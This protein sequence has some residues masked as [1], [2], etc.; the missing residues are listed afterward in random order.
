MITCGTKQREVDHH[1]SQQ[2]GTMWRTRMPGQLT[3]SASAACTN[4]CRFSDSV[5][6]ARSAHVEP[7][8]R[9]DAEEHQQ[10]VSPEEHH[11]HMTKMMKGSE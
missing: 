9:R 11:Q 6:R 3:P 1:G 7:Q 8:H 4:S 2:M 10:E 5:C